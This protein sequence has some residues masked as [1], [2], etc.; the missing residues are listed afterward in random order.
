MRLPSDMLFVPRW[1]DNIRP[2][3]PSLLTARIVAPMAY[4]DV[5]NWRWETQVGRTECHGTIVPKEE[6][7]AIQ[8]RVVGALRARKER[9]REELAWRDRLCDRL[10]RKAQHRADR[11]AKRIM[12]ERRA[13]C[14][15]AFAMLDKEE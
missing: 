8:A 9:M 11:E 4:H 1:L 3:G 12:V 13:A 7:L 6:Q 10:D 5:S 2:D 15:A 14:R